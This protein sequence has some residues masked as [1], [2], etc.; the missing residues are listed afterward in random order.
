ML[1]GIK[2]SGKFSV[3]LL[4]TVA[5]SSMPLYGNAQC[6]YLGTFIFASL[7]SGKILSRRSRTALHLR[8]I[9]TCLYL[10]CKQSLKS[11]HVVLP[12]LCEEDSSARETL[13]ATWQL[14]RRELMSSSGAWFCNHLWVSVSSSLQC[15]AQHSSCWQTRLDHSTAVNVAEAHSSTQNFPTDSPPR[16]MFLKYN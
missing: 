1:T 11:K 7:S 5:S 13:G 6:I 16:A 14:G 10:G 15:E 3:I 12:S 2:D 9:T 4:A 8:W